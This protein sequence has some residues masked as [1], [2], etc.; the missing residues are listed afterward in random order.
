MLK[1]LLVILFLL[2]ASAQAVAADYTDIWYNPAESGWGMNVVQSDSFMFLTFFIYGA[3][4]KPTWFYGQVSQDASSNY[5]GTL[6]STTGTYYI[7]PWSGVL[8]SPAGTVSFQPLDLYTAKLV[9]TVNGVGTVNKTVQRQALTPFSIAGD[10]TGGLVLAQSQCA[11]AGSGTL[12]VNISVSQPLNNVGNVSI[13]VARA[14]GITCTFTAPVKQWGK[15][16]QMQSA[17]YTCN[18]GR[19]TTAN[20]DELSSTAHGIEGTWSA[21]VEGGCVETGTFDAVMR[22]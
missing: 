10:Y 8:S 19:S 18:N 17:T 1:R 2:S 5:N 20:V 9:Y 14:D 4:G 7:L 12:T 13:G 3:D 6:Y 11:N 16:Y 15:L 21:L 22:Q